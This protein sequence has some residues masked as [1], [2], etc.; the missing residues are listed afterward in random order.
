[1]IGGIQ[2]PQ[3][4]ALTATTR[5]NPTSSNSMVVELETAE[6]VSKLTR[7]YN[8]RNMSPR[9]MSVM[10][11]ELYQSGAISF[12]DHA[13]LSF[14]PDLGTGYPGA[15]NQADTPK[16]FIAHWERQLKLHEEHGQV[17]F[18]HNDRRILNILGNLKAIPFQSNA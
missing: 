6:S 7:N 11:H 8:V 14:Q 18:A 2:R 4:H 17:S 9:E 3:T 16:D 10:S 12:E 13:L 5:T 15:T 1:M